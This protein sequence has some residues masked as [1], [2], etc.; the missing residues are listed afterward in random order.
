M[1][2]LLTLLLPLWSRFKEWILL[3]AAAI[4]IVGGA[5]TKGRIDSRAA[6]AEAEQKQRIKDLEAQKVIHEDVSKM[7]DSDLDRELSRWVQHDKE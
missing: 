2:I 6:E 3:A 5:Y 7:S 1:S 4:A